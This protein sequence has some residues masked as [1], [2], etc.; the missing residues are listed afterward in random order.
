[1]GKE[2]LTIGD[3][4]IEKDKLYRHKTPI[5]LEDVNINNILVSNKISSG[6]K[7]INALL[8]TCIM[9]M[10]LSHYI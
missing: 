10:K 6:E 1:M 7:A 4:E 8:V 2:I 5:F 9:I 3:I